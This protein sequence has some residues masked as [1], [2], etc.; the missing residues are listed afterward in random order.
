MCAGGRGA[1]DGGG[2]RDGLGRALVGAALYH[3][4]DFGKSASYAHRTGPL[5]ARLGPQSTLPIMLALV[6]SLV[7]ATRE[8]R[9]PEFRGYEEARAAW[10]G[11]PTQP[12]RSE[13]FI[14]LSIDGAL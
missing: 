2:A 11:E 12:A 5:I 6:R 13:D 10:D 4:A 3:Y 14:G 9:L 1:G 8:E 7:N